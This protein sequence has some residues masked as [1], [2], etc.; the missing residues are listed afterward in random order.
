VD[1][2]VANLGTQEVVDPFPVFVELPAVP[3]SDTLIIPA[4]LPAGG[5]DQL[6]AIPFGPGN[7]CFDP[8]CEAFATVDPANDI[9]ECNEDN[10]TDMLQVPG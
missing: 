8:D 7:N 6:L 9:Q 1:V 10:N 5:V 2:E 3:D 4:G